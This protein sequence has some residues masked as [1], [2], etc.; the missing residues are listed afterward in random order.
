MR[1][2]R[3]RKHA[4]TGA[5]HARASPPSDRPTTRSPGLRVR[6]MAG[7]RAPPSR[8][9]TERRKRKRRFS[10]LS[11]ALLSTSP[12]RRRRLSRASGRGNVCRRRRRDFTRKMARGPHGNRSVPGVIGDSPA[13][14]LLLGIC[15]VVGGSRFG[16]PRRERER[17]KR[18]ARSYDYAAAITP[19]FDSRK[20][21]AS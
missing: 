11:E 6:G 3:R 9:A 13:R 15:W 10:S 1:A 8:G 4:T 14:S 18:S 21:A 20:K 12:R 16:A 2:H 7:K 17:C 19:T 5:S